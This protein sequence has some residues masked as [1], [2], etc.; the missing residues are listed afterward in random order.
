MYKLIALYQTPDDPQSF[1]RHYH[2]V[3][4]PLVM[5]TPGLTKAEICRV[6][7]N[8]MGGE[9]PYFLIAEMTYPDKTTFDA[10]MASPQNRAAGKDL[11]TFAKGKVTLLIAESA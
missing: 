2:D 11:M 9:V 5:Q 8:A 10:A 6:T 4:M 3:H 1:L 7:A